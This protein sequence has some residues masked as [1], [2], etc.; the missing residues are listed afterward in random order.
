MKKIRLFYLLLFVLSMPISIYSQTWNQIGQHFGDSTHPMDETTISGDGS[1]IAYVLDQ[2][3]ASDVT[4]GTIKLYSYDGGTWNQKGQDLL[5]G[6]L[7]TSTYSKTGQYSLSLSNDGNTLIVGNPYSNQNGV[8]SGAVRV[9]KFNNNTW[10]QHGTDILGEEN[11]NFGSSVSINDSGLDFIVGASASITATGYSG[12][13]KVYKINETG[14]A[15][16][17]QTLLHATGEGS[18]F[19]HDVD[20]NDSGDRIVASYDGGSAKIFSLD[21]SVWIQTKIFPTAGATAVKFNGQGNRLVIGA[22]AKSNLAG[23]IIAGETRVYTF[24]NED[25]EQ[26]GQTIYGDVMFSALGTSVSLNSAGD[27]LA[28]G[29]AGISTLFG[30][31][32]LF[33]LINEQWV[34]IGEI[35]DTVQGTFYGQSAKLSNDGKRIIVGSRE[36]AGNANPHL[37]RAY[38]F[39]CGVL[40]PVSDTN[41][42]VCEGENI[43]L[44]LSE[45]EN[46]EFKWY[47]AQ[48]SQ[49]ILYTGN[50]YSI[51]NVLISGSYWVEAVNSLDCT[52]NRIEI[53]YTV[54]PLPNIVTETELTFCG[55]HTFDLSA[56]SE[57]NTIRWYADAE[58][59]IELAQ[60]ESFQTPELDESTNYWIEAENTTTGCLSGK[61]LIEIIK[62]ETPESP[63]AEATQT[64]LPGETISDLEVLTDGALAWYADENLETPL[65]EEELLVNG[66]TYY[67]TQI[68]NGCQSL[69]VAIQVILDPANLENVDRELFHYFP[70]PVTEH[71]NFGGIQHVIEVVVY[72]VSGKEIMHK[73]GQGMSIDQISLQLL[74]TGSYMVKAKTS[75]REYIFRILKK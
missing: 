25:W 59:L 40:N 58:G 49:E 57:G 64:F 7:V 60:G 1:V 35:I 5:F 11:Q 24:L 51:E 16:V 72:D 67:V 65:T 18:R 26:L 69:A 9:Y 15:Q 6:T 36:G 8:R 37:A 46:V 3:N 66:T 33:K 54:N 38:E 2:P 52:S 27:I 48:N 61:I 21:G 19:G 23:N 70:N 34:S 45:V 71:L 32:K 43:T 17:G 22:Y 53:S 29:S 30:K 13:V 28:T 44:E 47:V 50:S 20:I 42:V 73:N 12:M 14:N 63:T 4:V 56:S 41:V 39:D 10:V 55:K 74:A 62:I 31:V 68:V 75:E